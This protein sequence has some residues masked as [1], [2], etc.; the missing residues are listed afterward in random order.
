MPKSNAR[1]RSREDDLIVEMHEVDPED[2]DNEDLD[3]D[4]GNLQDLDDEDEDR[5][6]DRDQDDPDEDQDQDEDD[7]QGEDD[8]PP[9]RETRQQRQ[10]PSKSPR[11]KFLARLK[12][13]ER[14]IAEV[15]DENAVL[16]ESNQRQAAELQKIKVGGDVDKAKKEAD[17]KILELRGKL[18]A[19]IEA[20]DSKAQALLTEQ[21]ADVKADVK[22]AE[23]LAEAAKGTD[24]SG[25]AV[26]RYQRLAA[27][28][29]RKHQRFTTDKVFAAF[30][31]AV[32]RD[33]A[34]EGMNR[35]SDA[36]FKELD[37]RI[38]ERYPEEY[39]RT[40]PRRRQ[41]PSSGP[42]ANEGSNREQRITRRGADKEGNFSKRGKAF[43][44]SAAN[45][46]TMRAVG[47]DPDD[48]EDRK[49]FVRENQ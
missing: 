38:K 44:L 5:D 32:D 15:R 26:E 8:E 43:V 16:A 39:G 24:T 21:M 31:A 22:K 46:R 37:K 7:D 10:A 41:H 35:N 19:A 1:G 17:A 20:G 13:A 45:M 34:Q 12:R 29:K 11:D 40:M 4:R 2:A 9:R 3:E 36:Y 27:Q 30:A 49:T 28:W 23:A 6:E 42:D 14:Q 47:L 18:E 33:L 25:G 48:A